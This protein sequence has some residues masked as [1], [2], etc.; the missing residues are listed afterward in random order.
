M[1]RVGRPVSSSISIRGAL[2]AETYQV[3]Q[4]WDFALSKTEN[5]MRVRAENFPGSSSERWLGK[6]TEAISL[7]FDPNGRERPLVELAQGGC[8]YE[9]WK[10]LL[11]WHIT[12]DE[13]LLQD[14]LSDWLYQ[15]YVGGTLKLR[16]E[17]VMTY[18]KALPKRKE[19]A[20]IASWSGETITR[21]SSGLLKIAV[22]FGLMTGKLTREFIPYHLPEQSFLYLLHGI[23]ET[24]PSA[25][26]LVDSSDWHLYLMSSSDVERELLRLHQYHRLHYEVAGSLAQL[27]L[28]FNALA[29][30]AQE[31]L[32]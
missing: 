21:V 23:S 29:G 15:Q 12:R 13:I 19:F 17:D 9:I 24:E 18:L 3:F 20:P 6:L 5:L 2:I 26:D 14:F 11:L 27:K 28:P 32:R 1:N 8:S 30:Y 4:R 25:R 22:D 7:R 16:T 10:P 31:V